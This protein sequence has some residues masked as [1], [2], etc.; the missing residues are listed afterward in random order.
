MVGWLIVRLPV[1]FLYETPGEDHNHKA[2]HCKRLFSAQ[3]HCKRLL[4]FIRR[5]LVIIR[6]NVRF[7][8]VS[9]VLFF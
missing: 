5:P 8:I 3:S 9:V 7:S 2:T 1:K 6:K 4:F